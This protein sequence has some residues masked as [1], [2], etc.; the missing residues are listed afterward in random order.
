MSASRY[1]LTSVPLVIWLVGLVEIPL[2]EAAYPRHSMT[3]GLIA[4]TQ[5]IFYSPLGSMSI[6][7]GWQ[8]RM[9]FLGYSLIICFGLWWLLLHKR[10]LKN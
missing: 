3:A 8:T 2:R 5:T 6:D 9:I 1:I 7:R 4:L 10:K